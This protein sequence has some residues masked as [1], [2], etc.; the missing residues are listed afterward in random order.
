MQ[1]IRRSLRK[2][3]K[4]HA[5]LADSHA[6]GMQFRDMTGI[7]RGR[8][9]AAVRGGADVAGAGGGAGG[10]AGVSPAAP[11]GRVP[12]EVAMTGTELGDKRGRPRRY[13]FTADPAYGSEFVGYTLAAL[14]ELLERVVDQINDLPHEA[15][16]FTSPHVWFPLGWLPLHLAAS[17]HRLMEKVAEAVRGEALHIDPDLARAL[18]GGYLESHGSIPS[19]LMHAD[20]LTDIMRQV[21]KDVTK[22][23]CRDI[24]DAN[25]RIPEATALSTPRSV[26][27][28]LLW[29]WTYHSGHIGLLRLEWGSDYEWI[30]APAP[31]T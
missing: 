5:V 29:H 31:Q 27:M 1:Y 8:A 7:M 24:E 19:R 4:L 6:T 11:R 13:D 22:P 9:L 26:L 30:M 21:R 17:E 20:A 25:A 15:L 14:D 12:E 3:A 23:V 10:T 16:A 28:H 18:E 2:T